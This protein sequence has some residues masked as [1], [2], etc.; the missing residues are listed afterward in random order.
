MN[1]CI[2]SVRVDACLPTCVLQTPSQ[3]TRQQPSANSPATLIPGHLALVL[4][5]TISGW[6]AAPLCGKHTI[7]KAHASVNR[8]WLFHPACSHP[9]GKIS[10]H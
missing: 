1:V 2:R 7:L 8:F 6:H 3:A 9:N 5:F 10:I 4:C